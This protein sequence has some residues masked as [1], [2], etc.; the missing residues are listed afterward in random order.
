MGKGR[1]GKDREQA[2]V[3]ETKGQSTLSLILSNPRVIPH[4]KH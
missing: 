4:D 2:G 3:R 1:G